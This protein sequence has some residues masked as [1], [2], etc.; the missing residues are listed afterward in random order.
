MNEIHI[1]IFL[2]FYIIC[3]RWIHMAFMIDR[4]DYL[5]WLLSCNIHYCECCLLCCSFYWVL[6][7][8]KITCPIWLY[9]KKD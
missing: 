8:Q 4:V 1:L 2:P 5:I 3:K 6:W 9:S 7:I